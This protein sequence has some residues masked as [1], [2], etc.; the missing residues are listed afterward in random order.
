MCDNTPSPP[1]YINFF[2]PFK[3]LAGKSS[4][5]SDR[6]ITHFFMT[7]RNTIKGV[8]EKNKEQMNNMA[9]V[10]SSAR[11]LSCDTL[12]SLCICRLTLAWISSEISTK[13]LGMPTHLDSLLL[14]SISCRLVS[15]A[16]RCRLPTAPLRRPS[17]TP[18][19]SSFFQLPDW[20]SLAYFRPRR[21]LVLRPLFG[22]TPKQTKGSSA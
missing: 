16:V 14:D 19:L 21:D 17:P 11:R 3:I 13:L 12:H 1:R 22:F 7:T 10:N 4:T 20:R 18:S 8:G 9:W 5:G 6:G 15:S 2:K